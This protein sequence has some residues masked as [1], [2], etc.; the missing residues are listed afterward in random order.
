M[1]PRPADKYVAF[2]PL[3]LMLSMLK[4]N[5]PIDVTFL[6]SEEC[7]TTQ[8]AHYFGQT[9][10]KQCSVCSACTFNH[11]PDSTIIEQMLR[12]GHS[13]DDIWFDL[14]CNLMSSRTNTRIVY[15][16]TP[17]FAVPPLKL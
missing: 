17:E 10:D 13:F 3:L 8:I 16:G 14:N 5:A 11:Y 1:E 12:D 2:L 15:M 7:M 6:K 9:D 4:K